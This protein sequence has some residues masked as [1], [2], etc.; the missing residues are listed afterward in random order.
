MRVLSFIFLFSLTANAS[1]YE[2][3]VTWDK[4]E[5]EVCFMDQEIQKNTTQVL[6][7]SL[8]GLI[9]G[10]NP[11]PITTSQSQVV[12]TALQ[13]EFSA[14]KTHIYFTGFKPCSL[15]PAA[16][17][18]IMQNRS[19]RLFNR[20]D[21]NIFSGMASIGQS[22]V[23]SEE[24]YYTKSE[25]K[26]FILLKSFDKSVI[27]HEAGH[28]LG[29]RHEHILEEAITDPACLNMSQFVNEDE[30][31]GDILF[32]STERFQ[33]YDPESIMNYC[34]MKKLKDNNDLK[35]GL[36]KQDQD[37]LKSIY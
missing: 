18:V 32:S 4:N 1:V 11:K 2:P 20:F 26:S 14:D 17:V 35:H 9:W 22:G 31:N 33:N 29:L 21:Y 13:E 5:I 36:S 6:N 8:L 16:D 24:G 10:I 25:L 27:I 34:Y 7:Y 23:M 19:L 12:Q 15:A 30:S 28:V 37:L 3:Q